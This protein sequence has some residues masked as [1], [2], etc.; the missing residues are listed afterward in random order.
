MESAIWGLLGT[1]VGALTSIATTWL[2]ARNA[3]ILQTTKNSEDRIERARAFQRQ[4]IL[5]LQEE[6]HDAI[7]LITRAQ[8]H[9][10]E[11]HRGGTPWTSNRLPA[12]VDDGI[13]LAMRK[14][15]LLQERVSDDALRGSIRS[16]M[17]IAN[18]TLLSSSEIEA[19]GRMM[20]THT[21]ASVVLERM[22]TTLR[23]YY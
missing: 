2:S 14:V 6:L 20:A 4:T 1:V 21:E 22:G 13:R 18:S 17:S 5:D 3:N 12:E 10:E 7:R 9:D 11:A 16:L 23:S 19:K 8:L 15:S